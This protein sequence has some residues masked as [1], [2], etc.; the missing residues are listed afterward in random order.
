MDT[1]YLITEQDYFNDTLGFYITREQAKR[2]PEKTNEILLNALEQ[3]L[4]RE[5]T[6][7]ELKDKQLLN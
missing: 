2:L 3:G 1:I 6:P 7:E 4:I 5:A